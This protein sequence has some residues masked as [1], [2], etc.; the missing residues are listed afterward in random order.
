MSYANRDEMEQTRRNFGI[1]FPI[2]ADPDG[3][4]LGR[5]HVPQTPWKVVIYLPDNKIVLEDPPAEIA[6]ERMAFLARLARLPA[7]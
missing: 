3:A 4:M 2:L 1:L 6:E 7:N 5:I